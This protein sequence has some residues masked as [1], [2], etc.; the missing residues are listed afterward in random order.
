M[1]TAVAAG[2]NSSAFLTR[3]P[4]EFPDPPGPQLWQRCAI[5]RPF[6]PGCPVFTL[7]PRVCCFCFQARR[8][9]RLHT[10]IEA[11]SEEASTQAA[12]KLLKPLM[13]AV[14]MVFGSA[15]ALSATFGSKVRPCALRAS[16]SELL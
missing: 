13:T 7:L 11:A 12:T 8:P 10:A 1:V 15:A 9:C 5:I 6:Q 14:D 3:A 16:R 2:G 4:D